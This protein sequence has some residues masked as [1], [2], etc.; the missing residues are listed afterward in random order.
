M[1]VFVVYHFMQHYIIY[2]QLMHTVNLTICCYCIQRQYLVLVTHNSIGLTMCSLL[3]VI[4]GYWK[5][6]S[7][8]LSIR[9][10]EIVLTFTI[11]WDRSGLGYFM[12]SKCFMMSW[13]VLS[14]L[15]NP[16]IPRT[17]IPPMDQFEAYFRRVDLDGDGRI[18]GAEAVSFFQGSNL[19]KQVLA[20]V[21]IFFFFPFFSTNSPFL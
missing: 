5:M 8:I 4:T 18:S 16:S 20:Q 3:W 9:I 7:A 2:Q 12:N 14:C 13:L 10:C 15:T 6:S 21:L 17:R 11:P 1:N 19:T